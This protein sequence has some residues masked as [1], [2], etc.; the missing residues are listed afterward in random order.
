[1]ET[2]TQN[3][4]KSFLESILSWG[5]QNR[6][7]FAWRTEVEPF[8]ILVAEFLLQRSRATTVEKVYK[9]IFERW[10]SFTELAEAPLHE[11]EELI[12]PLGLTKRARNLIALAQEIH[13]MGEVPASGLAIKDEFGCFDARKLFNIRG[14]T[15]PSIE[16]RGCRCGD[17]L[18]G[19]ITPTECGLFKHACTPQHP[20][21]PCMVS[22]EGA[23]S[24]YYL[25]GE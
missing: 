13:K 14:T 16:H 1:M 23:C 11:L 24:S 4:S 3:R 17:V 10:S 2:Y 25:Y 19:V 18:R 22:A 8:K 20:L 21:G 6:R 5:A 15:A 7:G 9:K 12:R